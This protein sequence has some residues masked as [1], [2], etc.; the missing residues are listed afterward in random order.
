MARRKSNVQT[1]SAEAYVEGYRETLR[2]FSKLDKDVQ[3]AARDEVQ[4]VSAMLGA[5]IAAAGRAT[6]DRR[7]A[8][9]ASTLRPK[10]D[11]APMLLIGGKQTMPVSRPGRPPSAGHLIYGMEFGA[12][13]D[14]RN[15]WRFPP[16]TPKRGRGNEGYWI[17]PTLRR[18]GPKVVEMWSAA[19]EK[20]AAGWSD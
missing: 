7:N 2:A 17:Y 3:N 14:G 4:K 13:Q 5:E 15:G 12:N 8:F 9:L 10:R 18:Q 11:R 6:G 20:A 16:R 1:L 19:L